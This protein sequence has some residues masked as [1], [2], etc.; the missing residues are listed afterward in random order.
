MTIG[1]Y[2]RRLERMATTDKLTGGMNR[3][4]FDYFFKRLRAT[5]FTHPKPMSILI[6]DIDHFKRVNDAYGHGVGD[7]VLQ[8]IAQLLLQAIRSSDQ[9]CRW[10][11]EEFVVLLDDCSLENALQRADILRRAVEI[12]EVSYQKEKI[13]ITISVGVTQYRENENL[14]T[15]INR[16]DIALYRAKQLGRNRV[17]SADNNAKCHRRT[18]SL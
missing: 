5:R 13:H 18:P 1:G 16:A 12:A 6:L 9:A 3:Q 2:Q 17:E 4:A 15:F 11:G 14:D 7:L 10:G 8:N